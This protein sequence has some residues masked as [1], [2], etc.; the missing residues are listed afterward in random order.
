MDAIAQCDYQEFLQ[1]ELSGDD[2]FRRCELRE[3]HATK[4]AT[5]DAITRVTAKALGGATGD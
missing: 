4:R 2:V 1:D 3:R 5:P